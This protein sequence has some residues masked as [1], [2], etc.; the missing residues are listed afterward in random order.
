MFILDTSVIC[1]SH[2]P[3]PSRWN[4]PLQTFLLHR[5]SNS[6][7]R[8]FPQSVRLLIHFFVHKEKL[9]LLLWR[10]LSTMVQRVSSGDLNI[11]GMSF[12]RRVPSNLSNLWDEGVG[13]AKMRRVI[14][15][16]TKRAK[17]EETGRER[18][19]TVE[20]PSRSKGKRDGTCYIKLISL[21]CP[22]GICTNIPHDLLQFS[23]RAAF[24]SL[25]VGGSEM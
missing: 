17:R 13:L 2:Y 20:V 16:R 23:F 6:E 19:T 22:V 12:G 5:N 21:I 24:G 7:F 10:N 18:G 25:G 1:I 15:Q 14:G 9:L 4:R 3:D 11:F 8:T